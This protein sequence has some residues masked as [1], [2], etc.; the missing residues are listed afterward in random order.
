MPAPDIRRSTWLQ[1]GVIGTAVLTGNSSYSDLAVGGTSVGAQL[2]SQSYGR[3][4]ELQS[5]EY[6]M[7]YMSATG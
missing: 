5:D 6:G 1:I 2:L 7:C 3:S 4:A